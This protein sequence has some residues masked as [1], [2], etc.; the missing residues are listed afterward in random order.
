MTMDH[1]GLHTR[2]HVSDCACRGNVAEADISPHRNAAGAKR[3]MRCEL[4]KAAIRVLSAGQAVSDDSDLMAP[5]R[6]PLHQIHHVAKKAAD[7]RTKDMKN[8][9]RSGI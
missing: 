8:F 9:E 3:K 7:R 5:G 2:D 4:R 6:L 1:I